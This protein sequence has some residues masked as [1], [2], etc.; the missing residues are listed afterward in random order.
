MRFPDLHLPSVNVPLVHLSSIPHPHLP[1]LHLSDLRDVHMP[2]LRLM[3]LHMPGVSTTDATTQFQPGDMTFIAPILLSVLIHV[4]VILWGVITT[5]LSA[6][7][8]HRVG[9]A[10]TAYPFEDETSPCFS[11]KY[12][13]S[14]SP[15]RNVHQSPPLQSPRTNEDFGVFASMQETKPYFSPQRRCNDLLP[16][17]FK[18]SLSMDSKPVDLGVCFEKPLGSPKWQRSYSYPP[19]VDSATSST[20]SSPIYFSTSH[21]AGRAEEVPFLSLND[22]P[23]FEYG[24]YGGYGGVEEEAPNSPTGSLLEERTS[25]LLTVNSRGSITSPGGQ[26]S[27]KTNGRKTVCLLAILRCAVVA[28]LVWYETQQETLSVSC[29]ALVSK[30]PILL[31]N[32]LTHRF[33]FN[34]CVL[35]GLDLVMVDLFISSLVA[36]APIIIMVCR[37]TLTLP[38]SCEHH[39]YYASL[40]LI[41]FPIISTIQL[42]HV[43]TQPFALPIY[44][45]AAPVV[46]AVVLLISREVAN[47]DYWAPMERKKRSKWA[48]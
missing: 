7:T 16:V 28:P 47:G 26:N 6:W 35:T 30:C 34:R 20:T 3:N 12:T 21:R 22:N 14:Y 38:I 48:Y 42:A 1:N 15:R 36:I 19:E 10:A 32:H 17:P 45:M 8:S 44:R 43:S 27:E 41:V 37:F 13:I 33:Q 46:S 2:T 11:P 39:I 31:A 4:I 25:S 9:L 40:V 23:G 18:R 5:I 29:V 24:R